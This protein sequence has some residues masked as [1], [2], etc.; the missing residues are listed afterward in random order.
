VTEPIRARFR[1]VEVVAR[2]DIRR[3]TQALDDHDTEDVGS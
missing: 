2:I 1:N 3:R